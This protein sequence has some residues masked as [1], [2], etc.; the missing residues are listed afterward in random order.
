[1]TARSRKI[2]SDT[3]THTISDIIAHIIADNIQYI[4]DD[5]MLPAQ[6]N[7]YKYKATAFTCN[8]L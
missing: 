3:I 8:R 5:P 1:M 7:R 2:I 4:I 6:L